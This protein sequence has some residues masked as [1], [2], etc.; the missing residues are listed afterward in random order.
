MAIVIVLVVLDVCP[1]GEYLRMK[2][3]SSVY[4]AC[5]YKM[6]STACLCL[7]DYSHCYAQQ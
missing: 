7:C 4:L 3:I 6:A 5:N 2:T 1:L